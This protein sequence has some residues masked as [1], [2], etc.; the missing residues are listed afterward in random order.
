MITF[1]GTQFGFLFPRLLFVLPFAAGVLI[2]AYLRRGRGKKV[3]VASLL[4][5]RALTRRSHARK[6][7]VPPFRFFFELLLFTLLTIAAAGLVG[8]GVGSKVALIIDNSLSMGAER[9]EAGFKKSLFNYALDEGRRYLQSLPSTAEVKV[10]T[11]SP[12]LTLHG[13][14]FVSRSAALSVLERLS[15]SAATEALDAS[16]AQVTSDATLDSVAVV[17]DKRAK[18]LQQNERAKPVITVFSVRDFAGQEQLQNIA[19]SNI[20]LNPQAVSGKERVDVTISSYAAVPVSVKVVLEQL[21]SAAFPT[22][23]WSVEEQRVTVAAQSSEVGGFINNAQGISNYRASIIVESSPGAPDMD[24]NPLDNSAYITGSAANAKVLVVSP[25]PAASLG[26]GAVD[27]VKF[28]YILPGA[29]NAQKMV[30]YSGP[31][32]A[33]LFHRSAPDLLPDASALFVSPPANS[34]L[35]DVAAPV[36]AS[37]ITRW[38]SSH[39]ALSYLNLP[40]V[41]LASF[42]PLTPPL[43]GREL[44]NTTF[45]PAAFAGEYQGRKYIAVGFEL[46][47]FEGKKSPVLSIFVLNTLKWLTELSVEGGY[48]L[49][50]TLQPVNPVD[51]PVVYEDGSVV[52]ALRES[53]AKKDGGKSALLVR[54]GFYRIGKDRGGLVAIN[55]FFEQESNSLT[56]RILSLPGVEMA[57]SVSEGAKPFSWTI[58]IFVLALILTDIVFSTRLFGLRQEQAA[59]RA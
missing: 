24:T 2:Y 25:A 33:V 17:S 27:I 44:I 31:Q 8:Q 16:L 49:S 47:P 38:L 58:T 12:Q 18:S 11:A 4:L 15:L 50:G 51:G 32:T 35:F 28:E 59:K 41:R 1:L 21:K 39:P 19:I 6:Q 40:A 57:S 30:E 5:L 43:W 54:P 45:G 7:F 26:L 10:Y 29:L 13:E 3:T 14:G 36:A 56:P 9:R 55:S 37:D 20:S 53:A 48:R 23:Y 42:T 34:R 22:Q 46:F 52:E